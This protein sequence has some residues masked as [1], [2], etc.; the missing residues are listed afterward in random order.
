[1]PPAFSHRIVEDQDSH[2]MSC[3]NRGAIT[4]TAT[5]GLSLASETLNQGGRGM[6]DRDAAVNRQVRLVFFH[7]KYHVD[8]SIP[9]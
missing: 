2:A 7:A 3:S 4:G 8:Y 1:M 9:A 6:V 5:S